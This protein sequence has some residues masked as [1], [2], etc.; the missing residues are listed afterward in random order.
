MTTEAVEKG[1]G[2]VLSGRM[3]ESSRSLPHQ[4]EEKGADCHA[5]TAWWSRACL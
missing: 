3:R 5:L 4:F 1:Y 2:L